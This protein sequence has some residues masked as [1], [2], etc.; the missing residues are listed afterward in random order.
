MYSTN[1]SK[2]FLIFSLTLTAG[3]ASDY[4][5]DP[6]VGTMANPGT[7]AAPWSTLQ[8]VFKAGKTFN[9]G[10]VIY[11]RNG[12]HGAARIKGINSD[13]VTIKAQSGHSPTA[14]SL[15]VLNAAHWTISDLAISPFFAGETETEKHVICRIRDSNRHITIQNCTIN[16]VADTVDVKQW[17]VA[18]WS[19]A[20]NG[21]KTKAPHTK[22]IDNSIKNMRFGI[23]VERPAS[24][25]LVTGN[26]VENFSADGMIGLADNCEFSYNTVMNSYL[27]DPDDGD[28]NHDDGFQSWSTSPATQVSNVILRGNTIIN[29]TDPD[30]PFKGNMQ[31]IGCFDGMYNGWI[32][33]NNLVVSNRWHGLSLYGAIDCLIVN[34]T[35]IKNPLKPARASNADPGIRIVPHKKGTASSGNTIRNNLSSAI[36]LTGT[37]TADHNIT[38]TN[39][40]S[41]FVDYPNLDFHLKAGSTAIH[42]GSETLAPSID[43]D[44]GPRSTPYDVGCYS[45]TA[46]GKKP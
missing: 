46:E 3:M 12:Y 38:T 16:S 33:E 23:R 15:E 29:W 11:L 43:L 20:A 36:E 40:S 5:V 37:Y 8:A 39:Y 7:S 14:K 24:D 6:A 34:N 35:V 27:L 4:Y 45:H 17:S 19:K 31:G 13:T 28:S 21:I 22:L 18:D 9:A 2:L 1:L 25:S 42:A 44:Q 41:H 32:V 10:D 26:T 30:Q